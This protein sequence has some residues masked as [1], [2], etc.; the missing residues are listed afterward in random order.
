MAAARDQLPAELRGRIARVHDDVAQFSQ[1]ADN[2]FDARRLQIEM[3]PAIQV[4][5]KV[6]R[7]TGDAFVA[8]VAEIFAAIQ[9]DVTNRAAEVDRSVSTTVLQIVAFALLSAAAGTL[10]FLYVRRSVVQRLRLLQES[11]RARVEGRAVAIPVEGADEIA[12]MA[13]ATVFFVETIERREESL[14]RIFEA[15]PVA[16]A[17]VRLADRAVVRTN[18]RADDLFGAPAA[19]ADGAMAL[20]EVSEDYD[21]VLAG[22]ERDG[23]VDDVELPMRG[24]HGGFFWGLIAGRIVELD[25]GRH[26]LLG[27]TDHLDPE[28]RAGCVAQRQGAGRG[29]HR[30]EV[31]LPRQYEPRA[32]DAAERHHR[33]VRDPGRSSGALRHREGGRAARA[34]PPRRPASARS[35]QRGARPVED[36]GRQ[37]GAPARGGQS[38]RR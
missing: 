18:Q 10:I 29:R 34:H 21:R 35:D 31:D 9:Q 6:N 36:R 7:Q 22:L 11:M 25:D 15:A 2:I 38:C 33:P 8:S 14:K 1:G 19:G 26:A 20:F 3:E 32:E 16:L 23:V 12:T 24:A 4:A 17:L 37:A 13:N 28:A 5:L 30:R 27:T